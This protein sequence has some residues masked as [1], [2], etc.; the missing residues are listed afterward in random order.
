MSSTGP[1]RAPSFAGTFARWA[2]V[3]Y[4][5]VV[6]EA[7]LVLAA[8]PTFVLVLLLERD[9]S[10]IP[11]Y[12]LA[13]VPL[14]PALGA[15]LFAWRAFDTDRH[16][17]P[18]RHFWRGYR[19]GLADVLRTW[20]PLLAVLMLLA[21]NIV[22]R[23][24]AGVPGWLVGGLALLALALTLWGCNALAIAALLTFRWRDAARLATYYLAGRP[25]ATVGWIVLIVLVGGILWYTSDWVLV[26]LLSP[27]TFFAHRTAR[28]MIAE[29][30]SLH[31]TP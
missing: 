5:F 12:A 10:N 17:N 19:V 14:G 25:G 28:P 21:M 26:L 9:A 29:I 13:L 6:I 18:G 7:L 15:A 11:L 20:V 31:T 1:G 16:P 2:G 30:T 22:H 8:A 3:V 27:L 23:E 24:A 4:W